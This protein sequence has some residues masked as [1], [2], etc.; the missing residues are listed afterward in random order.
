MLGKTVSKIAVVQNALL[1]IADK[2]TR[3]IPQKIK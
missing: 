1:A 2:R 3:N